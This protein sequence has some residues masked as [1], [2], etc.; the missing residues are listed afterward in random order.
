MQLV[1]LPAR[2]VGRD[3]GV[4]PIVTSLVAADVF[5]IVA[6]LQPR[7]GRVVEA[8]DAPGRGGFDG[9]DDGTQ[10]SRFCPAWSRVL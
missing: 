10:R 9:G 7:A 6:L 5:P 2:R 8:V 3:V 4:D 1:S